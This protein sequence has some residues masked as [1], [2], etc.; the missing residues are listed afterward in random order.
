[1]KRV[2]SIFLI[3]LMI[4]NCFSAFAAN[5]DIAGYIYSTDIVAYIDGMAVP[6]YNI[7]GKTVVIAEEL[8]PYGFEVI[9]EEGARRLNV[10][11]RAMPDSIPQY[12]PQKAAVSGNI[13]GYIYET[14]IVAL[15][16]GMWVESYN[17]GGRTALVMEDMAS[18]DDEAKR[19]SRD[20][21][22]HRD[23]GYCVALMR[24]LWNAEERTISLNCIRPGSK[25]STHYGEVTVK[26]AELSSYINGAYSF[27][28]EY[29]TRLNPWVSFIDYNGEVYMSVKELNTEQN[30]TFGPVFKGLDAT[31]TDDAFNLKIPDESIKKVLYDYSSTR[32][33]CHNMLITLENKLSINGKFSQTETPDLIL[34]RGWIFV[35]QKAINSAFG[36]E[37]ISYKQN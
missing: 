37:L 14:D 3:V 15:V 19:M 27:Y 23:I 35:G 21:N 20:G 32:G 24:A 26:S 5:G 11:T 2:I 18:D 25:I 17:I 31:L 22:P 34:Y 33:S 29:D 9:W 16:N 6:S 8:E 36:R 1:M 30:D 10:Y 13:A 28:S 12:T 7:G 4:L